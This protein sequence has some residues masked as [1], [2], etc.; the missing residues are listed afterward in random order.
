MEEENKRKWI[1]WISLN[2]AEEIKGWIGVSGECVI[3]LKQSK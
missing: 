3:G 2:R 1:K